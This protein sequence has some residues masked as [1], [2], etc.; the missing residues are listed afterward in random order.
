MSG[1][2]W[3]MTTQLAKTL[4]RVETDNQTRT[5]LVKMVWQNTELEMTWP[6]RSSIWRRLKL[7]EE[8]MAPP[9][10]GDLLPAVHVM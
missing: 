8:N 2:G 7:R 5:Q 4:K 6:G 3:S 1:P 9:L 10:M